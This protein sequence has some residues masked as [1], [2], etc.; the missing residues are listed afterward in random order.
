MSDVPCDSSKRLL[1][2]SGF[3]FFVL[4]VD[5]ESGFVKFIFLFLRVYVETL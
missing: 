1:E 2:G 5:C 4:L 3:V